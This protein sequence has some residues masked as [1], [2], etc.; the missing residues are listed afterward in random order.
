[1]KIL[2]IGNSFSEDALFYLPAI[3]RTEGWEGLT[4]GNLSIG[5]CTLKTHVQ[6][7][8]TVSGT[9]PGEN[10]GMYRYFKSESGPWYD[11]SASLSEG[12]ADEDWDIVSLQ[13][14]SGSSGLAASYRPYLTELAS[15]VREHTKPSCRLAWHMTWAYENG[16]S[17]KEFAAYRQS[18]ADM[19]RAIRKTL[20][21]EVLPTG[22]FSLLLPAGEAI[23][24]SREMLGDRLTRDGYHLNPLGRLIAAY[25]WFTALT[26]RAP[27]EKLFLPEEISLTSQEETALRR[28]VHASAALSF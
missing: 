3:A 6:N 14:A 5:G 19:Y 17:H 15:F 27:G 16:S 4:L 1:M 26:G 9:V 2:A 10:P 24:E 21:T 22:F 18:Q 20:E 28:A 12:L 8:G 25:T 23:Q 11:R 13:Q 7:S